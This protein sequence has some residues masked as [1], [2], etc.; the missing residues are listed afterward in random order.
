MQ[1]NEPY[2]PGAASSSA[3][4]GDSELPGV[5]TPM[6]G[7]VNVSPRSLYWGTGRVHAKKIQMG[8]SEF[9]F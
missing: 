5:Q 9:S 2:D 6:L 1:S 8:R 7:P 3:G 4:G